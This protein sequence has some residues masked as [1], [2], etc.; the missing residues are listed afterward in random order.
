MTFIGEN[1]KA[2]PRLKD[3]VFGSRIDEFYKQTAELLRS[4]YQQC[5]LVH[6]DFSEYNLLF[7]N[8]KIYVI[9]VS[10]AVEHDHPQALYF[11]RRDCANTN[12]FFRKNGANCLTIQGLFNYITDL[13]SQT[14]QEMWEKAEKTEEISDEVF[15]EIYIPRTLQEIQ[16]RGQ[17]DKIFTG[18][19]GVAEKNDEEGSED[20]EES[21]ENEDGEPKEK[22]KK[23]DVMYLGL[24]KQER[25]SK[26]KEDKREKRKTKIPK[27]VKKHK[28]KKH[29][30]Q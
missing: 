30:Q 11:L 26:V 9:D 3:V 13:T 2:A 27:H 28:I 18:L 4:L 1:S 17:N 23:G 19:T 5:K 10:Q 22:Q 20:S 16:E 29:K 25:K 14:P 15:K 8:D 7:F 6:A 12:D 21:A 24:S